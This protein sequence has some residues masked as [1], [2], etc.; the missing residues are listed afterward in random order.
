M[1]DWIVALISNWSYSGIAF[2]ML[3]ENVFPP[4]PSELIMPLAGFIAARGEIG[5]AGAILAGTLGS[6]VGALLWFYIGRW[7]GSDRL[8]QWAVRYGRLLT[9]TPGDVDAANRWFALHGGRAVLFGRLV[10]GVRTL[11]SV[12]AGISNMSLGRLLIYSAIGTILWTGLLAI[13]GYLLEGEY[14]RVVAWVNPISN[15]FVGALAA[16]YLY[17][18]ATFRARVRREAGQRQAA[19]DEPMG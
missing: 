11:I 6:V 8:K 19:P 3:A 16:V 7:I 14:D 2:L 12:P 9:M 10:P 1:F 15:I 5:L 18:V 13:A 4:I 17:R